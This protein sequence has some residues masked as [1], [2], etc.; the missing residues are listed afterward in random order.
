MICQLNERFAPVGFYFY[1]NGPINYIDNSTYYAHTFW[2]GYSMMSSNNVSNSVNVYFV[3]D[4]NGNCGYFA[5][6]PDAVAIKNS[7]GQPTSTTLTHELGHYFG[8]PHTFYGWENGNTPWNPELVTRGPGAN[9]SFEGDMFCDTDADYL[10]YRW[11]CPYGGSKLDANGDEYHPDSSVYMSY[12]YDACQSRFTAQ[13]IGAMQSDLHTWRTDLLAGG[14]P[15]YTTLD[16]PKLVYPNSTVYS[17]NKTIRWNKVP[18][19][20]MYQV[21]IT[22]HP[23]SLVKQQALITDTMLTLDFVLSEQANYLVKVIPI[24]GMNVCREKIGSK[25]F[26]YSS[27]TLSIATTG[28]DGRGFTIAPNPASGHTVVRM[29]GLTGGEYA[30]ELLTITG[31]RLYSQA[32]TNRNGSA[33]LHIPLQGLTAGLYLLRLSGDNTVRTEK[34]IVQ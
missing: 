29:D 32:V 33:E 31:Q 28:N 10:D 9:C 3:G 30:V 15:V 14:H 34:L 4:P 21:K 25:Q 1:I 22:F 17:N 8:L 18:G 5:P 23:S 19:A 6:G 27:S 16:T 13:Q 7:C 2:E 12:S 26:N 24:S 20:E 11:Q